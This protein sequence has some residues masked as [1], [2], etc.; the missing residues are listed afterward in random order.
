MKEEN[1]FLTIGA[2][3]IAHLWFKG[4]LNIFTLIGAVLILLLIWLGVFVL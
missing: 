2:V 4:D 1:I 3:L